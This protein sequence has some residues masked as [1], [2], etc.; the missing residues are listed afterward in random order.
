[1]GATGP[2]TADG[3]HLVTDT[4]TS[5]PAPSPVPRTLGEGDQLIHL[6]V[7]GDLARSTPDRPVPVRLGSPMHTGGVVGLPDQDVVLAA[8]QDL[9]DTYASSGQELDR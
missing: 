7:R 6:D 4:T 8:C 9:A 1:M 2:A 5:R 3:R